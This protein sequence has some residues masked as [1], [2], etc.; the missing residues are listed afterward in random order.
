[1]H[2]III[3]T[4]I[5]LTLLLSTTVTFA[6]DSTEYH[7]YFTRDFELGAGAFFMDKSLELRVD[8]SDPGDNIE[9]DEVARLDN[10]DVSGALSFRWR[11]GEKWGFWAQGWKI[12]E[13]GGA[14]LTENVEW[15]D[16]EF[17]E[18]TFAEAGFDLGVVRLFLGRK[19]F[20]RPNQEFGV[21]IGAHWMEFDAFMEG[22]ILTSI[23]DTEFYR[24]TVEADF[25]LPNL[26]AW[27]AWSWS[28]KWLFSARLDWLDV[29]LGDYSG[30]LWNSQA[31]VQW[32]AFDHLAIGLFY[33]GF[34]LDADV[35]KSDWRGKVESDQHGPLLSIYTSW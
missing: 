14:V 18:G 10:D 26:G 34:L 9:F 28:P 17:R 32:Q 25:P 29:S 16:V 35:K 22:Q 8:G 23:G 3:Q 5:L 6:Q 33:S 20:E 27:Y 31:G 11:F 19:F 21:G 4:A 15:E 30:G 2:R 24:G 1:M 7:P 12:S 13:S